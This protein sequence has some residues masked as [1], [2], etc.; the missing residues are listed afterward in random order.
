MKK[1]GKP[2]WKHWFLKVI[3]RQSI[4]FYHQTTQVEKKQKRLRVRPFYLAP[5]QIIVFSLVF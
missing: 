3:K 2:F 5:S 4:V 1:L